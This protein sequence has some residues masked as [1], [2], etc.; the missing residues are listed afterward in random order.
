VLWVG[1][2][3][4][5]AGPRWAR[6]FTS[7][8]A[9]GPDSALEAIDDPFADEE[10]EPYA[11]ALRLRGEPL[12]PVGAARVLAPVRPSK[13]ICVGR[14]FR[15]HAAEL[16]NEVPSEPLLFFKPPSCIVA[17][18]EPVTL[19]RGYA[20]ID[21]ESE[22]V[23]VIGRGPGDRGGGRLAAR[24]RL[25]ARQRHQQPRPAEARQAVDAGQGL[26]RLRSGR[27]VDADDGAR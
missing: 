10:G 1:R 12:G 17:S 7:G 14:N 16:G 18:G 5:P 27:S 22:L 19:P 25:H 24:R 6:S 23:A 11:R 8:A 26:R 3:G 21:M 9:P 13:V 2:V 15:A 4:T 20:R